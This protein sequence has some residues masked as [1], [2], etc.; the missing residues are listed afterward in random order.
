[1]AYLFGG[2]TDNYYYGIR[3]YPYSTAMNK[4]P[5]TFKDI[6]RTQADPHS[7]IPTNPIWVGTSA[8]EVH[9]VGEVW[10]AMLWEARAKLLSTHGTYGGNL[11]M[12]QLVTEGMMLCPPHPTFTQA[13]DAILQADAV[14][15]RAADWADLWSA[16]AKRGLGWSAI[17]PDSSTTYGVQEFYDIAPMTGDPCE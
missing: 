5:L 11:F 6:D 10:C 2:L 16:F 8:S 4:S 14:D 13:R 9:N 3:R 1:V 7:G 17:A 12:L 15:N